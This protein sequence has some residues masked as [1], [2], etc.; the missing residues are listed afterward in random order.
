MKKLTKWLSILVI[1]LLAVGTSHAMMLL[2]AAG[3]SQAGL[4]L[5]E[6]FGYNA[7]YKLMNV[8]GGTGWGTN[9]W[10]SED[11]LRMATNPP[12]SL[13]YP[14][15]ISLVPS[16]TRINGIV[17]GTTSVRLM[18]SSISMADTY[19]MSFL[20][21]KNAAGSFYIETMN[22]TQARFGVQVTTNGAVQ[23]L[24]ASGV[25]I[26]VLADGAF[27]NDTTYMVL[28]KTTS[29]N[30]S[31]ALYAVGTDTVPANEISVTWASIGRVSGATQDRMKITVSKAT[32]QLDEVRF[33]NSFAS[34]RG[35]V[36]GAEPPIILPDGIEQVDI[37]LLMGQ[38]NMVGYGPLPASQSEYPHILNMSMANDQWIPA[39]HPLHD[40]ANGAGVGSGL[41]FAQELVKQNSH[42]MVALIPLAQGGSWID[43]WKESS[44]NY[45]NT[46]RRAKK[47]LA[48]FP[49]GTAR[50]AGVLW[51]QGESD[52]V[53]GRYAVYAGK[54]SSLIQCLR[55]DLN[56]PELPFIACTIRPDIIPKD[57]YL[58][59][60]EINEVLMS[61][62]ERV[63]NTACVDA[64]DLKG[65]IGDFMHYNTE[66][67]QFIG[68]RFAD[69]YF[70]LTGAK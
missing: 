12:A 32:A 64:R 45:D 18:E 15:G 27:A 53:D 20:A 23:M 4:I 41:D 17:G 54:L 48:G 2:L 42:V 47:A 65:H 68:E 67:Q 46:I 28:M 70:R 51:L 8:G 14:A 25:F 66:S 69:E 29:T 21:E 58:Y 33:G 37:F 43:L 13:A 49:Q 38:S 62:P 55:A 35:G 11:G 50:I 34:V 44:A 9:L 10:I 19:Y 56:E 16:G 59:V 36:T 39:R 63:H 1:S 40:K 60:K 22:A 31:L 5:S 26:N 6:S 30:T 24:N 61:L 52:S 57:K 7:T 3:T